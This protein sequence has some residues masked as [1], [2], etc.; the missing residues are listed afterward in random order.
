MS[1][2]RYNIWLEEVALKHGKISFHQL[3]KYTQEHENSFNDNELAAFIYK[4][5]KDNR[6][7]E[8][9]KMVKGA[10]EEGDKLTT[11]YSPINQ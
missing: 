10:E 1:K 8:Y 2:T 6:I 4:A 7:K 5:K 3:R 9:K 11:F